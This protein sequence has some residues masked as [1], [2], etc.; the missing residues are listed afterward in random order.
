MRV[1]TICQ[2]KGGCGK[3]TAAVNLAHAFARFHGKKVLLV[4]TDDQRN[5]TSCI[6]T[7]RPA[8]KTVES[9]L[10]EDGASAKDI[11]EPTRWDGVDLIAGSPGLSSAAAELG[12][13]SGSH[14]RLRNALQP[15]GYDLCLIDTSPSLNLITVNALCASDGIFIPLISNYFSLQGLAQTIDA[16]RKVRNE[17][18]HSLKLYGIA[19]VNH[20][21]RTRLANEVLAK[22]RERYPNE[23][24]A[25]TVYT[26]IK[27][28]E[29]Q[30]AQQSVF[31]YAPTCRGAVQY[32]LL[33]E[34]LA[35]RLDL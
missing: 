28:E 13:H 9:L 27:V 30:I 35:G 31:D 29:A 15:A 1:V 24:L 14:L 32:R 23:A 16:Y 18:H 10:L 7:R 6:P 33:A 20:Y 11:A 2:R 22:V 4:D 26:N 12:K 3:S 34:E 17:L 21:G 5:A 8:A 25:T 19:F